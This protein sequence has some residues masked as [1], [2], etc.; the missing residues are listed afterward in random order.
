[1][2]QWQGVPA[3]REIISDKINELYSRRYNPENEITITSGAT[4]ALFT[5]IT[6]VV[7]PG[8]EVI[9]FE[10]AYDSYVPVVQLNGGIQYLYHLT[11]KIFQLTGKG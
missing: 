10:P 7:S 8:D 9:I 5:A 11:K 4:E 3:L 2:L 6:A 1:M